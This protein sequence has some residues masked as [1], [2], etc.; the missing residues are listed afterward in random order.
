MTASSLLAGLSGRPSAPARCR[1]HAV[2]VNAVLQEQRPSLKEL[3]K[4]R[5]ENVEGPFYVDSTCIDWR[6][7]RLRFAT[8]AW[9]DVNPSIF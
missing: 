9:P 7:F 2:R 3:R 6:V 8:T 5:E 4:P 1:R